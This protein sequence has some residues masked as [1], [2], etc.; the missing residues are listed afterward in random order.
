[1]SSYEWEKGSVKIP[2]DQWSAF[3]KTIIKTYNAYTERDYR[4]ALNL[5]NYLKVSSKGKRNYNYKRELILKLQESNITWD[6]YQRIE[7]SL[8][9]AGKERKTPF[10][11]K[12]K[13]F[14]KATNQ[15]QHISVGVATIGLSNSNKTFY[16]D[17]QEN[18]HAVAEAHSHPIVKTLF[19][20]L[21][22]L[23]WKRNSGGIIVGNDEYNADSEEPGAGSNY[24]THAYGPL[25]KGLAT[26][27]QGVPLNVVT[28]S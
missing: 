6:S 11:P 12:M 22:A 13:D 28:F 8:F 10:K 14:P 24:I 17:V 5:Y 16:W 2:A 25:G 18:N 23:D 20:T 26:F 9:P 3:K 7:L 15:T 27:K 21:A 19:L 4:L 1:M